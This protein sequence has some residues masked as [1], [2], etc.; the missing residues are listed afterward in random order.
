VAALEYM[1]A[2]DTA[3]AAMQ[4]SYLPSWLS[5]VVDNDRARESGSALFDAVYARWAERPAGHRPKLLV[6]GESLGAF[7]GDGAFADLDDVRR[8]TDGALWIGPP[9]GTALWR[10]AVD[11]R[12]P[13][14]TEALP[15]YR[16]DVVRFGANAADLHSPGP[17]WNTPRVVYLQQSSDPIVWWSPAMVLRRPDW[18]RE[19]AGRDV[20]AGMR[21]YPGVTFVQTTADLMVAN[22]APPG[23]G[24]RY[25][26]APV[27]AWAAI[28]APSGWTEEHSARLRDHLTQDG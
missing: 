9:N 2:G 13:G 25:G 22:D 28:A 26:T 15:V 23:H 16:P 4:Y 20:T 24:H 19:R 3:V 21:W 17:P 14:S 6:F 12:E 11:D 27:D 8:R 10:R 1:Y 7:G 5:F 18:L